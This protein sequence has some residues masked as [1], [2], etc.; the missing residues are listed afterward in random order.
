MAFYEHRFAL[1]MGLKPG[2]KVLDVG[3]GI[4]GPAREIAKFIGCHIVGITINQSQVDRAVYLTA[5]EGLS[6]ECTFIRADFLVRCFPSIPIFS[7]EKM[8]SVLERRCL[9]SFFFRPV[10]NVFLFT[11]SVR[12]SPSTH[13]LSTPPTP[14]KPPSTHPPLK[15][16]MPESRA[17]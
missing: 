5:Q 9:S 3:C 8:I 12:T 6:D 4:G 17:S 10:T 1:L 13:P 7:P 15:K 11:S 14:S 2:M 16:C